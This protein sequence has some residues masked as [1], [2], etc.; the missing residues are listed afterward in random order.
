MHH[1]TAQV[2]SACFSIRKVASEHPFCV[3]IYVNSYIF[4]ICFILFIFLSNKYPLFIF[5]CLMSALTDTHEMA[6]FFCTYIR[7][8]THTKKNRKKKE[9]KRGGG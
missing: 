7:R 3:L 9:R 6:K 4:Q 1:G 5:V 8:N 2:I